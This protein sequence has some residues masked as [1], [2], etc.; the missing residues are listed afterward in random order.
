[1]TNFERVQAVRTDKTIGVEIEFFGA[2]REAVAQAIRNKG[3]N[4]KVEGWSNQKTFNGQWILTTD[5]S[6]TGTSTGIGRGLELVSPPLTIDQMETQLK[7]VTDA[8]NEVGAKVDRTAGI[9]VHHHIDDLNV[10]QI[11]N[12]YR[13][14]KKHEETLDE[15]MPKS[16]R[17][18]SRPRYCEGLTEED[19][20]IVECA[21]AISH[22]RLPRYRTINFQ[23][24]VKYGTIEFR[25]HSGSTDFEK[26]FN[27]I[28][29]TQMI[30]AAA[31]KK[32]TIRPLAPSANRT[33][34]FNK[35]VGIYNTEQGIYVR[36]R[37]RALKSA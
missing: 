5:S 35:E 31:A 24:Y 21:T 32:K 30:V 34:A 19:M 27:W 8:L 11:K 15:I 1:M 26:I 17:S 28:L 9:H 33:M 18:E 23:S 10:E 20:S 6:V 4:V 3:I 13:I 2:T 16:R 14:Y 37:K 25:H 22:L 36:D 12:I 7:A 29:I